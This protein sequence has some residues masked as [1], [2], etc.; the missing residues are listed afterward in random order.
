MAQR[1]TKL[2]KRSKLL[3][4]ALVLPMMLSVT[5]CS[6]SSTELKALCNTAVYPKPTFDSTQ[7][8]K[9]TVDWFLNKDRPGYAIAWKRNCGH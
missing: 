4:I 9:E 2:N 7:D 5:A 3:S 1:K 8:S 6:G